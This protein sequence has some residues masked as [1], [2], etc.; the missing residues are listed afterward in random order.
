MYT[1][2][3]TQFHTINKRKL[4]LAKKQSK[5]NCLTEIQILED[6]LIL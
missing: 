2:W 3:L 5:Y 1:G 4:R 6:F